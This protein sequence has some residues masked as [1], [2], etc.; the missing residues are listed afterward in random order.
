[1]VYRG[2]SWL[3]VGTLY[4]VMKCG[5]YLLDKNIN[6]LLKSVSWYLYCLTTIK[7]NLYNYVSMVWG[8][9]D[10]HLWW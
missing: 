3:M 5:L 8:M 9:R 2:H 10:K 7:Q 4:N 6:K 1:M